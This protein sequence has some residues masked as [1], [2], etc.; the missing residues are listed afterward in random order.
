MAGVRK[1][2]LK[3]R[4]SAPWAMN[5]GG[6]GAGGAGGVDVDVGV[7]VGAI[8]GGGGVLLVVMMDVD[9]DAGVSVGELGGTELEWGREWEKGGGRRLRARA[10]LGSGLELRAGAVAGGLVGSFDGGGGVSFAMVR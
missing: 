6:G 10:E 5:V 9:A 2:V 7:G 1:W 3:T 8:G 4:P